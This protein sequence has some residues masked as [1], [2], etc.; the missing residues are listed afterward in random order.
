MHDT[1]LQINLSPGDIAYADLTVPALVNHHRA[2]VDQ[3]L[4]IVDCCKPQRTKIVNPD[5][6]FPEPQFAEKVESI[7]AIAESLKT[8]GYLDKIIYLHP[9]DSLFSLL[10][11]KYLANWVHKTHDYG[12]CALMS[13]LAGLEIPQ[14]HYILHY[15]ADM[16]LYQASGYDWSQEA[17]QRMEE[18]DKTVAASPRISPPFSQ[19]TGLVDA[20]SRHE[21]RPLKVVEGGWQND[22]FS[23]RC[24]LIDKIK[25]ASYLPL[26]RG[27]LLVETLATKYLN[28]GYPRSPE[29]MLFKRVGNAGG[30]R[31][32]LAS[33]Q[34]WLLYPAT[35]P[36]SYTQLLPQIQHSIANGQ[37]PQEQQGYADINLAAWEKFLTNPV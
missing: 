6:R 14:T 34:A 11:R 24:Y 7:C 1:T 27:R 18:H 12:G 22:W 20:P 29:I 10:S 17:K 2:S 15:D 26:I 3:T 4:A 5:Q 36:P 35:K 16:L 31:I 21:E 30:R 8:K 25:L 13:Y 9:N 23:T 28:R 37:I 19:A 32:N 33:E